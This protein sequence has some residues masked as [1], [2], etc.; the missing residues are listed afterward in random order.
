MPQKSWMKIGVLFVFLG[1]LL[2]ISNVGKCGYDEDPIVSTQTKT[3][4]VTE[5]LL[6]REG[7]PGPAS[8]T[9]KMSDTSGF[10]VK[11]PYQAAENIDLVKSLSEASEEGWEDWLFWGEDEGEGE[12]SEVIDEK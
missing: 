6:K 12:V 9:Y 2:I 1:W 4:P 7:E 5:E 11:K 3:V 10:L 8:P